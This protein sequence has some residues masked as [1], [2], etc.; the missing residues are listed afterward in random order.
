MKTSYLSSGDWKAKKKTCKEKIICT[1]VDCQLMY[2]S[3]VHRSP[4]TSFDLPVKLLFTCHANISNAPLSFFDT[5]CTEQPV[6]QINKT[7]SL[8]QT[9]RMHQASENTQWH[10]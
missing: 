1:R 7:K 10:Q 5:S 4:G 3:L 9:V 8:S 6:Q 2:L